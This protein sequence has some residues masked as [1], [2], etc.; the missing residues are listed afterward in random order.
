MIALRFVHGEGGASAKGMRVKVLRR[1]DQVHVKPTAAE[2]ANLSHRVQDGSVSLSKKDE[3]EFDDQIP[4]H[5]PIKV[6]IKKEKEEK[7]KDLKNEHWAREFELELTNTGDKNV[8]FL[9]L[10][11]ILPEIKA[12]DGRSV[13]F[14]LH[15]G[16]PEL[17]DLEVKAN[18]NDIP[19]RPGETYVFRIPRNLVL[20]HETVNQKLTR[21]QPKKIVLHFNFLSFG[22][23]TGFLGNTGLFFPRSAKE[24]SAACADPP[25]KDSSKNRNR[26]D[27][28]RLSTGFLP[29]KFLLE[30]SSNTSPLA[31]TSQ[32]CCSGSECLQSKTWSLFICVN[33]DLRDGINGA[34]CSDPF[35]RCWHPDYYSIDCMNPESGETFL[36]PQVDVSPCESAQPTP[37]PPPTTPS[38]SPTP[39]HCPLNCTDPLADLPADPCDTANNI[40]GTNCPFGYSQAGNCCYATCREPTYLPECPPGR[41]ARWGWPFDCEWHCLVTLPN[42]GGGG[43]ND[44]PPGEN[45]GD[46]CEPWYWVLF[47]YDEQLGWIEVSRWFAFCA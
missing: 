5:L 43:G 16:R 1:K 6:K 19:I 46:P 25:Y 31:L 7:F 26:I 36:C 8:Y 24:V 10:N 18:S 4:K 30:D 13:S 2:I 39:E 12:S 29:V 42:G 37:T 14:P 33:C 32:T 35:A 38:P 3:R 20:A 23:G 9:G 21:P 40:P 45:G 47:Q 34:F 28:E 41:T 15:Y 17:S 11:L 22:D 27:L 44:P